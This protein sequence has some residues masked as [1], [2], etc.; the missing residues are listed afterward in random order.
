MQSNENTYRIG[1]VLV[2]TQK[3]MYIT[4]VRQE[5][6]TLYTVGPIFQV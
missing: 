6:Y 5:Q 1:T 4:E 2:F 3:L